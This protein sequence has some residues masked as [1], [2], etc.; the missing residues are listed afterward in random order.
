MAQQS[1]INEK[2]KRKLIREAA[3]TGKAEKIKQA[4]LHLA[5]NTFETNNSKLIIKQV[6]SQLLVEL[7]PYYKKK[8]QPTQP[9]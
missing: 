6:N 8:V 4:Q 3:N 1:N 9:S 7:G 2:T 5:K